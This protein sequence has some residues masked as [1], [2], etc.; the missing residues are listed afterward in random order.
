[1]L[2]ILSP[3]CPNAVRKTLRTTGEKRN[4]KIFSTRRTAHNKIKITRKKLIA[5]RGLQLRKYDAMICNCLKCLESH[6]PPAS[7]D[8]ALACFQMFLNVSKDFP[9]LIDCYA[10]TA[11]ANERSTDAGALGDTQ[12]VADSIQKVLD[13]KNT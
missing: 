3:R 7:I 4:R 8:N 9:Y 10:R 5:T 2:S 1:M 12:N 13:L 11:I 6:Q